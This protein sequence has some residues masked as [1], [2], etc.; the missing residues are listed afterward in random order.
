MTLVHARF[1]VHLLPIVATLACMSAHAAADELWNWP[2]SDLVPYQDGDVF[3]GGDLW[4]NQGRRRYTRDSAWQ[5]NLYWNFTP[6]WVG[7]PPLSPL[8]PQYPAKLGGVWDPV[9]ADYVTDGSQP[10]QPPPGFYDGPDV[11]DFGPDPAKLFGP[12]ELANEL[13][14]LPGGIPRRDDAWIDLNQN[15]EGRFAEVEPGNYALILEPGEVAWWHLQNIGASEPESIKY[16][17]LAFDYLLEG[18]QAVDGIPII[19]GGDGDIGI[20]GW[21]HD[22]SLGAGDWGTFGVLFIFEPNPPRESLGIFNGLFFSGDAMAIDNLHIA[23]LHVIPS[24]GA[25][26][27]L[28]LGVVIAARRRR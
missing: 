6:T 12:E 17:W 11:Y 23:T 14:G 19:G 3:R 28:G 16:V 10:T 26:A 9:F 4:D 24:P 5:R 2:D 27:L 20:G 25:G 7:P 22:P 8:W 15:V 1:R 18:G 13:A 21:A